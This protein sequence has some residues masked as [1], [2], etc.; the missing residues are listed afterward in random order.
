MRRPNLVIAFVLLAVLSGTKAHAQ[1]AERVRL[2]DGRISFMPPAGFK[3]MPKE[4]IALRFG[5]NGATD[6]PE[7]VYRDERQNASVAV[8]FVGSGLR[9]AQLDEAK[10]VFEADFER[11]VPGVEWIKREIVTLD[12]RRWM[13][14]Y[15]K[16]PTVDAGIVNDLYATIFD[17]QLLTFSFK[18]S[19]AEYEKYKDSLRKSAQSITVK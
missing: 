1:D 9:A 10:K 11:R 13:H 5:R 4:E 17:G 18:S 2:K 6:A 8:G 16:M 3:P 14:L 7:V 15:V 19:I 12:G